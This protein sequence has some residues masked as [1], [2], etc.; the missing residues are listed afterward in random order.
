[1]RY[2][3]LINKLIKK[4]EG[5]QW[6]AIKTHKTILV[7]RHYDK[8]SGSFYLYINERFVTSNVKF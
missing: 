7:D 1:M 3:S 4:A 6:Y 2:K 8:V 5:K